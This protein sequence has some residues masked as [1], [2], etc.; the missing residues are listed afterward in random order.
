MGAATSRPEAASSATPAPAAPRDFDMLV[1]EELALEA[2][3]LPL[4]EV[5][6]CLTLFDKWLSCYALGPQFR[7]VYRYGTAADC[8]PQKEDF[9]Y[10]LTLRQM[11]PE[12][13]RAEWL[14]R[15]AEKRA[16]ERLGLNSSEAVWELRRKPLLDPAFVD[17]D[18]QPPAQGTSHGGAEDLH[19]FSSASERAP[20][21]RTTYTKLTIE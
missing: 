13:R 12:E 3:A 7:H 9:K 18:F 21:W 6:S 17:P 10:C 2:A 4:N 19:S 8:G 5:P 11:D 15:R 1:R 20:P 14:R 16:H